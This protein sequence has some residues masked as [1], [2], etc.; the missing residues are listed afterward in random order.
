MGKLIGG[1]TAFQCTPGSAWG[2]N[3]NTWC[4]CWVAHMR[5]TVAY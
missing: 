2:P 3:P 4:W 1:P 5:Q